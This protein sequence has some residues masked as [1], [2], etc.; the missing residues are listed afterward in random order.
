MSPFPVFS[1]GNGDKI[2]RET[3]E[4]L[5]IT[6]LKTFKPLGLSIKFREINVINSFISFVTYSTGFLMNFELLPIFIDYAN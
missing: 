2:Y 4:S 6:K 3:K 1:N 5:W